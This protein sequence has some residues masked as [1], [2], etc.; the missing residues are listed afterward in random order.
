M[1]EHYNGHFRLKI[2]HVA[3]L[4]LISCFFIAL[5]EFFELCVFL[6]SPYIVRF[7]DRQ[8]V[9]GESPPPRKKSREELIGELQTLIRAF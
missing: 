7:T 6:S 8:S 4:V 3:Y 5:V 1:K 2:Q 9:A